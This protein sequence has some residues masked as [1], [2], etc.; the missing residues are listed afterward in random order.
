LGSEDGK[1]D[2]PYDVAVDLAGN[3]Y[4]ADSSND[5]IQKFTSNGRFIAKFGLRGSEDGQLYYPNGVAVS[6]LGKTVYVVDTLN[7]RVQKFR[8]SLFVK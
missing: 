1:F 8:H 4:V 6:L 5:R 3:V 7:N 2:T